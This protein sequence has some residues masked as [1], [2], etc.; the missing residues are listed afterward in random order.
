MEK[1]RCPRCGTTDAY[2]AVSDQ[3]NS[4]HPIAGQSS[5][6]PEP[7]IVNDAGAEPEPEGEVVGGEDARVDDDVGNPEI[8]ASNNAANKVEDSTEE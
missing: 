3:C 1:R 6:A 4:C 7:A 2:T 8:A 5:G